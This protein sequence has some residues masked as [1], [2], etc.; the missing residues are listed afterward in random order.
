MADGDNL[1]D[2]Y[3]ATDVWRKL[4]EVEP[5]GVSG[6]VMSFEDG[7]VTLEYSLMFPNVSPARVFLISFRYCL[8]SL[9]R[10]SFASSL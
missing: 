6:R 10:A 7:A 4:T 5:F 9:S 3:S 1:D 8:F 2:G